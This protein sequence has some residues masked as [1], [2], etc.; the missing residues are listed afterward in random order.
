MERNNISADKQIQYEHILNI[1]D[2]IV[3]ENGDIFDGHTDIGNLSDEK[4]LLFDMKNL[5]GSSESVQ[6]AQIYMALSMIWS[7]ALV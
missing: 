1:V 2:N 5:S 4:I 7:Q 6:K 3:S